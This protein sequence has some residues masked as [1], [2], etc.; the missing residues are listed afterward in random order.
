M[1]CTGHVTHEKSA[2]AV[3]V[4]CNHVLVMHWGIISGQLQVNISLKET[5]V[6]TCMHADT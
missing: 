1:A 5:N 2:V 4:A 6:V 3:H